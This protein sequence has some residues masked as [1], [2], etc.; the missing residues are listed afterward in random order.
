M[1]LRKFSNLK[2]FNQKI[3]FFF[4]WPVVTK[5]LIYHEVFGHFDKKKT[6]FFL[7]FTSLRRENLIFPHFDAYSILKFRLKDLVLFLYC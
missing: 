2:L 7:E 6:V 4:K 5:L 3:V 1:K